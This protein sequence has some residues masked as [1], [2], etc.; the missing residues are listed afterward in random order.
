H[1]NDV[2]VVVLDPLPGRVVVV[3]QP[4]TDSR[5]LVCT[6]RRSDAAAADGYAAFD[7]PCRHSPGERDDE[8]GIIVARVQAMRPEIDYLLP[9]R[10]EMS[11]Q[12]LLQTKPTM[13]RGNSYVHVI[14][15]ACIQQ[16]VFLLPR[17]R[18]APGHVRDEPARRE[19]TR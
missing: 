17:G 13:I 15:L 2:H 1:A 16:P 4:G 18:P 6:D 5:Y 7:R 14:L 8:G 10:A 9:R 19:S 11:N 3:H 12:F